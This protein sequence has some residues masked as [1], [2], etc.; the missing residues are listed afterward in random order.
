MIETI[1]LSAGYRGQE[2]LHQVNLQVSS[3]EIVAVVGPNGCG[4][5]TLLK[6]IAGLLPQVTGTVILD[7]CENIKKRE[8][9]RKIAILPQGRD[10]PGITAARLVLHGR[11]PHLD[12]P[13]KYKAPDFA[14]AEKSMRQTGIYDLREKLLTELSGGERQRVYLAMILAQDTPAV[15][16]DEPTTYLDINHQMELM[17]LV[18]ALKGEGKAILMVLHDLPLALRYADRIT[19]M[20]SG[21]I[22]G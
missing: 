17:E 20:Q 15:L 5:S 16:L 2:E 1:N 21:K 8:L 18:T 11:F 14:I 7:G 3:G 22:L 9:A 19:V 12:Y 6:A 10:I 4:K 13:R